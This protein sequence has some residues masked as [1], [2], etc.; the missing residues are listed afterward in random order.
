ME[1][2]LKLGPYNYRFGIVAAGIGIVFSLMLY[3]MDMMY[4]QSPIIQA[5]NVLIPSAVTVFAITT[6]KKDNNGFLALKQSIKLGAGIFLVTGIISLLYFALF[7]NVVEP[8]FITNTAQLQADM[9]REKQPDLDESF[10]QMQQENTE[11]FFYIS[12][13]FILIINI[14]IGLVVGLITG[15]VAKKN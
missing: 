15:L 12:F 1:T 3:F 6:F 9:L 8:D 2:T 11:K 13:P 14:I 5:I 4:E 10:I 7:I